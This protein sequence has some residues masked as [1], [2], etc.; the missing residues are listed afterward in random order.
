MSS[1]VHGVF[2][3]PWLCKLTA[4]RFLSLDFESGTT[5]FSVTDQM[6]SLFNLHYLA[7]T[8]AFMTCSPQ[9][10]IS[11]EA[12]LHLLPM[13]RTVQLNCQKLKLDHRVLKLVNLSSLR[14]LSVCCSQLLDDASI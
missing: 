12:S 10:V 11:L 8:Q 3:C 4:L 9:N 13:L 1:K 2:E 6:L 5:R 14:R 7:I